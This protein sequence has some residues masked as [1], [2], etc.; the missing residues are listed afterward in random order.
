[1]SFVALGEATPGKGP[2]TTSVVFDYGE[3]PMDSF[4]IA[5]LVEGGTTPEADC[6]MYLYTLSSDAALKH[7]ATH[8]VVLRLAE[9]KTIDPLYLCDQSFQGKFVLLLAQGDRLK[10]FHCLDCAK[11]FVSWFAGNQPDWR[12]TYN[13]SRSDKDKAEVTVH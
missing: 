7:N 6:R 1:M 12:E 3:Y 11:R 8:A 10:G 4:T 9:D 5:E 13:A 2:G